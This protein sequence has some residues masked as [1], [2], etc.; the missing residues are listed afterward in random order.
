MPEVLAGRYELGDELGRGGMARVLSARDLRL[1]RVVAVKLLAGG[2]DPTARQRFVH[3]ARAAAAFTHP[4]AVSVFD[5][6]ESDGQLYLV[7]ELVDGETLAAAITRRGALPV[8]EA[9][10]VVDQVLQALDAA[11][12]AGVVHRDVKPSNVLLSAD[13]VAKLGDFGIAKRILEPATNLT[14][15]GQFIGTPTHLAPEQVMGQPVTPATDVY[16]AGV[17]LFELLTAAPPFAGETPLATAIAHR[18]APV[19]DVRDRRPDVPPVVAAALRRAMAKAPTDRFA[20]AGDMRRALAAA[21]AVAPTEV[22]PLPH[23]QPSRR[24]WWLALL[25]V[26]TVVAVAAGLLAGGG[27]GGEDTAG[28]VATVAATPTPTAVI[29]PPPTPAAT[30][31][32]RPHHRRR[33]TRSRP[34]H[35]PS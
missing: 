13:G 25:G 26:A 2:P 31:P 17:L 6:G 33:R 15:T 18:D 32:R 1:D 30:A 14:S 8:A 29:T 16:S 10:R 27:D 20:T 23:R 12:R 24:W 19:P 9:L 5:A 28:P 21:P 35:P 4:H 11:H 34:R 3:E 7:M 22:L